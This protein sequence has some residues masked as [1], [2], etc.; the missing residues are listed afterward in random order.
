M[1]FILNLHNANIWQIYRL[2]VNI[3]REQLLKSPIHSLPLHVRYQTSPVLLHLIVAVVPFVSTI[4]SLICG[5]IEQPMTEN[6]EL[7]WIFSCYYSSLKFSFR[8]IFLGR[9][10]FSNLKM[11][12]N[13]IHSGRKRFRLENG[14]HNQVHMKLDWTVNDTRSTFISFHNNFYF[15]QCE[16]ILKTKV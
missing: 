5:T 6:K 16:N 15:F 10:Y 11:L 3:H 1:K 13:P 14:F 4:A 9:N 12:K 7:I 8:S 2:K